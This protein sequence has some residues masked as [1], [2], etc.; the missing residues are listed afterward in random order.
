M[1]INL[2]ERTLT[3]AR[4]YFAGVTDAEIDIDAANDA[5]AAYCMDQGAMKRTSRRIAA[6]PAEW[7][8]KVWASEAKRDKDARLAAR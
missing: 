1:V 2:S 7:E 5:S 3:A 6:L 4:L 8:S